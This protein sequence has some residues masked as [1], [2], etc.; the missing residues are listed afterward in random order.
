[1]YLRAVVCDVGVQEKGKETV[2]V[3]ER[4]S[5]IE[6]RK[7]NERA[8]GERER[9]TTTSRKDDAGLRQALRHT[10]VSTPPTSTT[11]RPCPSTQS[12]VFLSYWMCM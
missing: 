1:M 12:R 8:R 4:E 6:R 11:S 3:W 7:N 9:E 2:C 10:P 5:R